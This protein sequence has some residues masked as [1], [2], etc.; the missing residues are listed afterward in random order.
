MSV[1]SNT[2]SSVYIPDNGNAFFN[3]ASGNSPIS[4]YMVPQHILIEIDPSGG[5]YKVR[6]KNAV[7][8]AKEMAAKQPVNNVYSA[9][10]RR[11]DGMV[12][13]GT[14]ERYDVLR[15][16][17]N[18]NRDRGFDYYWDLQLKEMMRMLDDSN[19]CIGE[20]R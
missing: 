11:Y 8:R 10:Y 17:K 18:L 16:A 13:I 4:G 14:F 7:K 9:I 1:I 15:I 12:V 5:D 19:K 6:A 20:H 3:D 2:V